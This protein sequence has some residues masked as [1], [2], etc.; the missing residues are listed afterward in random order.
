MQKSP[1]QIRLL[2][3]SISHLEEL[4]KDISVRVVPIKELVN[5]SC[6]TLND[7]LRDHHTKNYFYQLKRTLKTHQFNSP[8]TTKE[9]ARFSNI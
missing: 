1:I 4:I 2:K 8:I 7:S 9:G 5:T 6:L 3:D